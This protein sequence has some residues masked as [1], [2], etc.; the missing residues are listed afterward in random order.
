MARYEC[1]H[2]NGTYV[3][4]DGGH[5]IVKLR[6]R[7]GYSEAVLIG[8]C[9]LDGTR[10]YLEISIEE[11]MQVLPELGRIIAE[12]MEEDIKPKLDNNG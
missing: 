12:R 5:P 4:V 11:M 10:R 3:L 9:C 8:V 7:A 1:V 2:S 6:K